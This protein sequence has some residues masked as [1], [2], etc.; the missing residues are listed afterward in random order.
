MR[1][2]YHRSLY[3]EHRAKLMQWWADYLDRRKAGKMV[4]MP[5]SKA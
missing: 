1:A 3:L 4:K 2:A 5:K